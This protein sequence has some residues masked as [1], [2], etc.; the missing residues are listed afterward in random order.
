M[1]LPKVGTGGFFNIDTSFLVSKPV[2]II[3]FLIFLFFY[4]CVSFVLFYHWA[5]YGMNSRGI[6][7]ARGLFIFVS[8]FL[9][10]LSALT[11]YYF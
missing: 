10:S 4:G 1:E 2:L 8:I 11:I 5:N 7:M 9:L 6:A 3:V